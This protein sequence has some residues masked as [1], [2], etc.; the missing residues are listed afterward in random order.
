IDAVGRLGQ[1]IAGLFTDER[2]DKGIDL[3]RDGLRLLS[4]EN[5]DKIGRGISGAFSFVKNIDFKTIG[6]GLKITAQVAKTAVDAF[7][8]LPKEAQ[9]IVIAALAANKLS[10][11]L[12]GSGIGNI[13]KGLGQLLTGGGLLGRGS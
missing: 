9:G 10:G 7:L 2:I 6:E 1:A 4:P 3:L 11:G 12:I 13:A 5:L 8:S